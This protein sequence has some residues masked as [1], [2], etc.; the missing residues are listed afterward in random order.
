M[1]SLLAGAVTAVVLVAGCAGPEPATTATTP[2]D[3]VALVGLWKLS[4]DKKTTDGVLRISADGEIAWFQDCLV[5]AGRW[6]ADDTGQF[7]GYIDSYS[8][9]EGLPG[10]AGAGEPDYSKQP[11]WLARAAGYRIVGSERLLV[12][13]GGATVARLRPGARPVSRADMASDVTD[14]PT[15]TDEDRQALRAPVAPLPA[16]LTPATAAGLLGR[17]SPTTRMPDVYLEF[18]SG[19]WEGRDGC[20][21]TTGGWIVGPDGAIL[22]TSGP[23]TLIGCDGADVGG[24]LTQAGRAGF[25]G[26]TLVLLDPTGKELGRLA[27]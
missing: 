2:P 23:S 17:W 18:R 10:C 14:V 16:D 1:R 8:T 15:V 13:A 20:N 4:T 26:V 22:S 3:P 24:W 27:R 5:P 7:V 11:D 21:T 9:G 19:E 12:D 25:D 6:R